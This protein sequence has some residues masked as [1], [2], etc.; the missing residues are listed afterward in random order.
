MN[1]KKAAAVGKAGEDQLAKALEGI[2]DAYV[3]RNLYIPCG[4]DRTIEIDCL[5]ASR[6]GLFVIECKAWNG[7]A[8][9]GSERFNDW[10]VRSTW[11]SKP[12]H[13]YS[14][15]RQNA[16]HTY[17][18]VRYLTLPD[19]KKP[20]SVIVFT[21]TRAK[22]YVPSN[23]PDYTIV[24]GTSA[25]RIDL[26]RRLKY[27]KDMFTTKELEDIVKQLNSLPKPSSKL[28]KAHIKQ[29]KQAQQKRL[30]E[31]EKRRKARKKAAKPKKRTVPAKAKASTGK[32]ASNKK[33]PVRKTSS[34]PKLSLLS[35][36]SFL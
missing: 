14:P 29:A 20:H 32:R 26:M 10:S 13:Y 25:L 31:K 28:K 16:A 12:I 5:L 11:K 21:S 18:L 8:I 3:L 17:K 30:A 24:Q 33:T 22:L 9:R 1:E 15:I 6:K 2:P 4:K 35:L 19:E 23:T 34:K 27:H 36:I 7:V